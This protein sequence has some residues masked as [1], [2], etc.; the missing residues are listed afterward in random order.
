MRVARV[1]LPWRPRIRLVFSGDEHVGNRECDEQLLQATVAAIAADEDAYLIGLGDTID[2]INWHDKRFEPNQLADWMTIG[3]LADIARA[4]TARYAEIMRPVRGRILALCQ[5]NHE[6]ALGHYAERDVYRDI[7]E[8]LGVP[9]D[10][11]LG[12]GGFLQI[13]IAD[14]R[15]KQYESGEKRGSRN[16]WNLTLFCHHGY[17][18]GRLA[19]AKMLALERLP[20][21][22]RADIYAMGHSHL[23]AGMVKRLVGPNGAQDMA[24][25]NVGAYL[26]PYGGGVDG[27]AE[28]KLLY[29]QGAGPVEVWLYPE[30]RE[31]KIVL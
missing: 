28:R 22:F 11:R 8:A 18:N 4:E 25:L 17:A 9:P 14:R 10:R 31:M 2:A 21:S 27:Y 5:G 15:G 12:F 6:E 7:S 16:A 26:T 30:T 24:L 20:F 1:T 19:G 13:R 3:D 23:K 29:P